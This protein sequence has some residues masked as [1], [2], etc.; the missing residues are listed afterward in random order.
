MTPNGSAT[1]DGKGKIFAVSNKKGVLGTPVTI[2]LLSLSLSVVVLRNKHRLIMCFASG[3]PGKSLV[4]NLAGTSA[5]HWTTEP[6][7]LPQS[8]FGSLSNPKHS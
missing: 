7:R 8:R 4:V 1:R 2:F 5:P 6:I 3:S